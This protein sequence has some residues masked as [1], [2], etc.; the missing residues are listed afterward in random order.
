MSLHSALFTLLSLLPV[1]TLQTE[2]TYNPLFAPPAGYIT[3]NGPLPPFSIPPLPGWN[4]NHSTLT[5]ICAKSSYNGYQ[6]TSPTSTRGNTAWC[7]H[8]SVAASLLDMGLEP[9]AP[10]T[11]KEVV[12]DSNPEF[13]SPLAPNLAHPRLMA[14]CLLRCWCTSDSNPRFNTV[15]PLYSGPK[16]IGSVH[17]DAPPTRLYT[18]T[19]S[20][21]IILPF[22]PTG[23]GA[24]GPYM[25][26]I[27]STPQTLAP[28]SLP[29][30]PPPEYTTLHTIT[31]PE[32]YIPRCFSNLPPPFPFPPINGQPNPLE[33][34]SPEDRNFAAQLCPLSL[35]GGNPY[36]NAGGY[37]PTLQPHLGVMYELDTAWSGTASGDSRR[38]RVVMKESSERMEF[39]DEWTPRLE[40]TGGYNRAFATQIKAWCRRA[41]VCQSGIFSPVDQAQE[42]AV[43]GFEPET[44]T[45]EPAGLWRGPISDSQGGTC[46][47]E[48]A[49]AKARCALRG[50]GGA[51]RT[52]GG[53]C[54]GAGQCRA[55]CS[56]TVVGSSGLAYCIAPSM[57]SG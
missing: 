40:W 16:A 18:L 24:I 1:L 6:V 46:R 2:E 53:R 52:C 3:C 43:N 23:P 37:C 57:L 7:Y 21:M 44:R 36:L 51:R 49:M 11:W 30:S 48:G 29:H 15:K 31:L 45:K 14:Y 8:S 32:V 34:L 20:P 56:C 13:Y 9:S 54:S 19:L 41:C 4:P 47:G 26:L 28:P 55:G 10:Q 50:H 38:E 42:V 27:E 5:T 25:L 17:A 12:F 39:T 35:G 22:A 33:A